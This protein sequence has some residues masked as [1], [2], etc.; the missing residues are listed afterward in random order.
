MN[1]TKIT[2][3]ET[4]VGTLRVEIGETNHSYYA[5]VSLERN[6]GDIVDLT[7]TEIVKEDNHAEISVWADTTMDEWTK[8]YFISESNLKGDTKYNER[9]KYQ[10]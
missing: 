6:D 8:Q 7:D 9:R 1:N 5:S 3:I 10:E 4:P 2:R